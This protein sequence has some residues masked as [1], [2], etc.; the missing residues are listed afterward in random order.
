MIKLKTAKEI[1]IMKE[2]GRR[3]AKILQEIAKLCKP[4]VSTM[5]LE[6]ETARMIRERG[7]KASFLGYKPAG[8]DRPFPASICISINDEIVHGIPN[9]NLTILKEGDIVSLDLGVTHE[10]LI[11]D[12]AITVPVGVIDDE[13]KKLIE[14]TRESLYAGIEAAQPGNR[15]GDIGVAVSAVVEKSGFSLAEDLV[16]HGVGYKVHEDPYVPN[17]GRVGTGEQIVPGMVLAL[18]PM[19]NVGT[20]KIK[21]MGDGYTIKTKDGSRSAHFEHSIAILEKGNIIL[22]L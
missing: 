5:F 13:S 17:V 1:E 6:E 16:G 21:V 7:D 20:A 15:I 14:V 18:E 4:G 22:T 8:A 9:E 3:H 2:G 19:V 11:T 10:G 12:A